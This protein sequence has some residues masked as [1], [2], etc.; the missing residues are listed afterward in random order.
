MTQMRPYFAVLDS[1]FRMLLQYR[2]VALAGIVTQLFFGLVRAMIFEGF[3]RSSSAPQPL[4]MSQTIT[5]IWLGQAFLLIAMFWPDAEIMEMIRSGQVAYELIRPRDLY[6]LW[7]FR[8]LAGRAA[9]LMLRSIPILMIAAVFFHMGL[10]ASILAAAM[11]VASI[12]LGLV[13]SAAM[14]TLITVTMLWTISGE[15][16]GALAPPVIFIASGILIPIPLFPAWLQPMF[17]VLPFRGLIDTPFRLYLGNLTG[18]AAAGALIQQAMWL[19]AIVALG[20]FLLS[21]G[22]RRLVVQGG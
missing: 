9:P 19:I 22:L 10:P 5:Y 4:T 16:V 6:F 8:C 7:F 13:L 21:R 14:V 18:A 1:R 11:F 20:R 17:Y 3:Y 15:G 2:A 12:F